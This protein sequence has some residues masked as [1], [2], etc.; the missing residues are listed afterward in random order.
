MGTTQ[1]RRRSTLLLTTIQPPC[2]PVSTHIATFLAEFPQLLEIVRV[3]AADAPRA[4]HT[5]APTAPASVVVPAENAAAGGPW[6]RPRR[7]GDRRRIDANRRFGRDRRLDAATIG[8]PS[9]S[10]DVAVA[11]GSATSATLGKQSH[12]RIVLLKI[13]IPGVETFTGNPNTT[14]RLMACS[15]VNPSR[16]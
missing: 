3:P 12:L 5:A 13:S 1:A 15:T 16:R 4:A 7:A 14:H 9:I 10:I 2:A 8:T 11:R 6:R